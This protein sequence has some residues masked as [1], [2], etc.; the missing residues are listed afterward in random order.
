MFHIDYVKDIPATNIMGE[1]VYITDEKG[2]NKERQILKQ[3]DY[4]LGRLVDPTFIK[5]KDSI[6]AS[7]LICDTRDA[8][9]AQAEEAEER[10]YW[11]LEDEQ[12]TRLKNA[13]QKPEGKYVQHFLHNFK[14]FMLALSEMSKKTPEERAASKKRKEEKEA[15][16]AKVAVE[17]SPE[18]SPEN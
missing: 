4:F 18:A 6:E 11:S 1:P 13:A 14:D 9:R 15:A 12:A 8:L 17:A 16:K 2:N 10:G 3:I 7:V 5:D